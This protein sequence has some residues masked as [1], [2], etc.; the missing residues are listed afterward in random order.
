MTREMK[1]LRPVAIL[2]SFLMLTAGAVAQMSLTPPAAQTPPPAA[3]QPASKPKPKPAAA[4]KKSAAAKPATPA[5]PQTVTVTPAPA[6][7]DPNVDL[8]YGAD[9]RG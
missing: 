8:V 6:P 1:T 3:S 9:Q 7:D 5:A 2:A 4:A